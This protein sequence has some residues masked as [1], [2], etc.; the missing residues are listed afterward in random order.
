MNKL[1]ITAL[2]VLASCATLS[3]QVKIKKGYLKT[4]N[5]PLKDVL[6]VL[7]NY[8]H[9]QLKIMGSPKMLELDVH[10]YLPIDSLSSCLETLQWLSGIDHITKGDTIQVGRLPVVNRQ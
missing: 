8:H 9:M 5:R 10:V 1:F 4:D 7:A 6:R 3:A 2:L